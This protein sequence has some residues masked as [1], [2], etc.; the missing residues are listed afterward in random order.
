MKIDE[1]EINVDSSTTFDKVSIKKSLIKD[2][3]IGSNFNIIVIN[4]FDEYEEFNEFEEFDEFEEFEE[5]TYNF[6]NFESKCQKRYIEELLLCKYI[7][8]KGDL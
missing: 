5:P 4:K 8:E 3:Y 1:I 7:I 2:F 6:D